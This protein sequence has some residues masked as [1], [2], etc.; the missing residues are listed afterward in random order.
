MIVVNPA[1]FRWTAPSPGITSVN[2]IRSAFNT[3]LAVYTDTFVSNLVLK[4]T[5]DQ[6]GGGNTSALT[7]PALANTTYR[8]EVD[9]ESG[10][11]GNYNLNLSLSPAPN[12]SLS[13]TTTNGMRIS[14]P[15]SPPGFVLETAPAIP[16]ANKW[17][18]TLNAVNS[19]GGQNL[20]TYTNQG[21]YP[22]F[23]LRTQ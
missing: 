23:R 19:A 3:L 2:T 15:T 10:A 12:L 9:G 5:D 20:V 16:S 11:S 21:G 13:R 14:W 7:F 17:T 6:S 4:A 1:G 18:Q 8:I 22:I